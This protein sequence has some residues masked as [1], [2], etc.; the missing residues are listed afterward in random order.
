MATDKRLVPRPRRK[1]R[2][3][4]LRT[5]KVALILGLTCAAAVALMLCLLY[6]DQKFR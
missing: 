2:G 4:Q 6:A 3:P 5:L 1:L